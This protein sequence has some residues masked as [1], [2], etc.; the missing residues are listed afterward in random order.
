MP[1]ATEIRPA[2]EVTRWDAEADVIVV[3]LGCAGASAA[4]EAHDLG[5]EVLV[6]ERASGGG[7]TSANSGGLIYMGG[8]TPVQKAA[9]FDDT[10]EEL[11][12]F[13]MAVAG[14][15]LQRLHR[16]GAVDRF[17]GRSP[18]LR[19]RR[20]PRPLRR[21]ADFGALL[22]AGLRGERDLARGWDLLRATR[23]ARCG[24][25]VVATPW[26]YP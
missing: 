9:G 16:G 7:G 25:L 20:D 8:G 17:V 1:K 6:V 21:G 5:A 4:M 26:P 13:L 14:G 23:G 10:P 2:S 12:K 11:F 15:N 18:R 24:V 22:R 19:R 3:G